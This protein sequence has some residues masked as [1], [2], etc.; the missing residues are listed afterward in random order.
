MRSEQTAAALLERKV[1]VFIISIA[2]KTRIVLR[3]C[4]CNRNLYSPSNFTSPEEDPA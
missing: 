4:F 3:R 1:K 2:T